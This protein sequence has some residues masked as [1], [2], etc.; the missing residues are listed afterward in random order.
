[1]K[2]DFLLLLTEM[3]A[4][5]AFRTVITTSLLVKRLKN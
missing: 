5:I 4:E 1:M 3:T 2:E